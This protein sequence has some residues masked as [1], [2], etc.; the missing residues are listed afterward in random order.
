MRSKRVVLQQRSSEGSGLIRGL[1]T[2]G[3]SVEEIAVGARV[4]ARTVYRW[5]NEGRAPHPA[6]LE[7]LRRMGEKNN[8][9]SEG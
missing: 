4:S 6:F 8:A 1:L 2:A 9:H 5:L 3:L 7:A